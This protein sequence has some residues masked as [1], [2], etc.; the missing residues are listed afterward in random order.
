M[1]GSTVSAHRISG[2]FVSK[3]F[4]QSAL[5][6]SFVM[7]ETTDDGDSHHGVIRYDPRRRW[8]FSMCNSPLDDFW[9]REKRLP[10]AIAD[11]EPIQSESCSFYS[12]FM[13]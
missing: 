4:C 5:V 9:A 3:I 12:C 2:V 1:C 7:R 10:K 8:R 11:R 6:N 13:I